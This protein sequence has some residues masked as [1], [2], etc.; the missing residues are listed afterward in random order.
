MS[1]DLSKSVNELQVELAKI[2]KQLY[3]IRKQ[4][5]L[6]K[7]AELR[8]SHGVTRHMKAR[9]VCFEAADALGRFDDALRELELLEILLDIDY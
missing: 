6:A 9:E 2:N 7:M 3:K 8:K 4:H 1:Q 5:V